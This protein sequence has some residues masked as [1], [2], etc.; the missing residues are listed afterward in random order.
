MN[1]WARQNEKIIFHMFWLWVSPCNNWVISPASQL[2]LDG[3]KLVFKASLFS[4]FRSEAGNVGYFCQYLLCTAVGF[5]PQKSCRQINKPE[6][7]GL[8][9]HH[10]EPLHSHNNKLSRPPASHLCLLLEKNFQL[11]EKKKNT[12]SGE[13]DALTEHNVICQSKHLWPSN[14]FSHLF[15]LNYSWEKVF[16]FKTGCQLSTS[17]L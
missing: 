8:G 11:P 2:S 7:P 6:M 13:K 16:S 9:G 17:S 4:L 3:S 10:T 14:I 5:P 15:P 12:Q 1:C